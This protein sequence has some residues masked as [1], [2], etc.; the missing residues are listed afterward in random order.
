MFTLNSMIF[1]VAIPYTNYGEIIKV[2]KITQRHD[3]NPVILWRIPR[4]IYLH[5]ITK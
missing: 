5:I 3:E 1:K 2:I 4:I